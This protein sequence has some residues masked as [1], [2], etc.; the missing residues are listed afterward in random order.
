TAENMKFQFVVPLTVMVVTFGILTFVFYKKSVDPDFWA[1]SCWSLCAFV[2]TSIGQEFW[3]GARVR[4]KMTK[5]DFFTSLIG[6][7]GRSKRR[8]GGYLIHIAIVMLFFG[9]A[10]NAYQKTAEASLSSGEKMH[11]GGFDIRFDRLNRAE[12]LQ[13]ESLDARVTV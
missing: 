3:R 13:K 11:V 7:V 9:W 8:Y 1:I 6:L 12:D 10:G 4:Q 2:L 5:L